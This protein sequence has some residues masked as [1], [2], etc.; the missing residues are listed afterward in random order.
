[1]IDKYFEWNIDAVQANTA[2][3]GAEIELQ[4]DKSNYKDIFINKDIL[5]LLNK[6]EEYIRTVFNSSDMKLNISIIDEFCLSY[7]VSGDHFQF[8]DFNLKGIFN[9]ILTKLGVGNLEL[10]DLE[11]QEEYDSFKED[12][13]KALEASKGKSDNP[14]I[15]ELKDSLYDNID[16]LV[17]VLFITGRNGIMMRY[18]GEQFKEEIKFRRAHKSL[19]GITEKNISWKN[20]LYYTACKS[21]DEFIYTGDIAY[22]RYA[23]NYYRNIATN[24]NVE[25]PKSIVVAGTKY[26]YNH[27]TF[28]NRFLA[29]QSYNFPAYLVRLNIEDK[30]RITRRE[31][32]KNGKG[33]V[34][35]IPSP[36]PKKSKKL[37]YD[38]IDRTLERKITF[39]RGLYSDT[40]GVIDGFKGDTDYVGYVLNNNYVVFDKFYETSKDGTRVLPAYGNRVYIATLD[41]LEMCNYDRSKLR[42][43]IKKYH[44]HKAFKYN[45]TDSDSYQDRIEEVLGYYDISTIKFK[46]LKL[47]NKNNQN[48]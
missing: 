26:E 6:T 44:D 7:L 47:T 21:L 39:Y 1:M 25:Y 20:L 34:G 2:L 11:T 15:E 41:V 9:N 38:K 24:P 45:H 28:R 5:E 46:E 14:A 43:Y 10:N 36:N 32:L 33:M 22:Y 16:N 12:I 19:N 18:F 4:I 27:E 35:T 37:D 23:K 3:E 8:I 31:T 40:Q 17:Y 29:I 13:K 42:Q 30:D 48:N